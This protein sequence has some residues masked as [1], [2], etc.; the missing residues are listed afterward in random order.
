MN[1]FLIT[2][3][4]YIRDI[5]CDI[6]K[7]TFF[8]D[9]CNIIEETNPCSC[10]AWINFT[11][12]RAEDQKQTRKLLDRLD[13]RENGYVFNEKVRAKIKYLYADMPEWKPNE[14]WYKKLKTF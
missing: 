12:G 11:S 9:H 6:L 7:R 13:Y 14:D 2:C 5:M 8:A 3:L 4:Y 10:A 1:F